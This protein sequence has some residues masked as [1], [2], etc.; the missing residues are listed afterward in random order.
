MV[1]I[2]AEIVW[3]KKLRIAALVIHFKTI[4]TIKHRKL[5]PFFKNQIKSINIYT[6]TKINPS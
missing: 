4:K 5:Y 6:K 1:Y 2:L 3:E